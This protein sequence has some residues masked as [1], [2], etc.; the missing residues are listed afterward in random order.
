MVADY[1]RE[2]GAD[3]VEIT[4]IE[5]EKGTTDGLKITIKGKKQNAPVLGIIGPSGRYRSQTRSQWFLFLMEME[6]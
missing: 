4:N 2:N 5:G 6:L 1:L 3:K